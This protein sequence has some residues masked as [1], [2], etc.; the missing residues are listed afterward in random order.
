MDNKTRLQVYQAQTEN[1]KALNQV[2][3]QINRT[4]N[5]ALRRGDVVSTQVQTKMFA[6]I[7][8]VWVEANFSKLIHTPY[9]FTLQEISQIKNIYKVDGLEAG[10]KKC[11]ELALR[12]VYRSRKSNY[13]PNI[14][15][16]LSTIVDD[17][18]VAPSLIRNKIAHGQWKIALNRENT[19]VNNDITNK[20]SNL[21]VVDISIWFKVHQHLS[22]IVEILIESPNKGFHRN[23][24]K[25]I[26]DLENFLQESKNMSIEEKIKRLKRKPIRRNL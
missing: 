20:L 19:A 11:I 23:Y 10:W 17:Y 21:D 24:W 3:I 15:R 16:K 12:K 25:E 18:I 2:R 9:G 26:D 1:V 14:N 7:F 4:I 22:S 8:C 13:I 5:Y 6:L